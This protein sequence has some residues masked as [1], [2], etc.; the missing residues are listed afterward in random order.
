VNMS[1]VVAYR[2]ASLIAGRS[3]SKPSVKGWAVALLVLAGVASGVIFGPQ[4]LSS[5]D[6][7]KAAPA[8]S[9][10]AVSFPLQRDVAD[11][12]ELLGQFS[13]VDQV[14]LR[15]QVGG[16]L[17]EIGFKDGDI[18]RKGDLLFL[19]DPTPYE[20]KLSSAMAQLEGAKAR[21]DLANQEFFRADSLRKTGYGSIETADQRAA[22]QRAARSAVDDAEAAI[23]DARFDLDHTRIVA[24]FT[25]RIG[26]H[27]VSIGNLISGSR[28]GTSPTTLLATIVST[29]AIYFN[30]DMSEA[31]YLQF[32]RSRQ[33][34][35]GPLAAKVQIA[36][37]DEKSFAHQ[38]TL[39]FVDN[40]LDRSSGTIHAR[41]TVPNV[42]GLLTPGSFGRVRVDIAPPAPTLFVPDVSVLPDQ[43]DHIVLIVGSDN[44]VTPKRVAL[45]DLRD[46][47]RV[48][49]SGLTASDRVIVGGIPSA[50][51][52]AV[53]APHT[54]TIQVA[55]DQN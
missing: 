52:G 31:D 40:T 54:Q 27:Q 22:E 48:V 6:A 4:V 30:F 25:G 1:D 29:D 37:T 51:P 2:D 11:R 19:I 41:A 14:E 28:A 32:L 5:K 23:R 45:G 12:L 36:L 8:P 50:R 16:T 26:S 17:T 49:R 20:I 55:S 13:P 42:D 33:K 44:V 53:V 3:S 7:P 47:L 46:G 38:G 43:S 18:V 35:S 10:V 21:L 9:S 34:Q 15:A 24:P 39:D